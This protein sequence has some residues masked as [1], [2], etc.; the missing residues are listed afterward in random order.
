MCYFSVA[1][2]IVHKCTQR[3][4]TQSKHSSGST[5]REGGGGAR[6]H[7]ERGGG[8]ERRG[9]EKEEGREGE[10]ES[11][12]M[13]YGLAVLHRDGIRFNTDGGKGWGWG[14]YE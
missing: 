2:Q 6:E 8:R 1:E 11:P 9:R 3:T 12:F 7:R 13:S 5:R 10:R 14:T 4:K